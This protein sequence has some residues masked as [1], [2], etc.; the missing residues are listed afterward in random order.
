MRG[1]GRVFS[2]EPD[3]VLLDAYWLALQDWTLQDFEKAA[4]H[5]IGN[6]QFMPRPNDFNALRRA[7]EP[8]AGEAWG[9]ALKGCLQWRNPSNLP[10]GRIARAAAAVGGFRA[11][12]MA[13]EATALPHIERRFKEAY[14]ELSEVEEIR[15][16]L[17]GIAP[18]LDDNRGHG[19]LHI[20]AVAIEDDSV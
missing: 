19:F 12:A 13:D 2:S 10:T 16:A 17:P 15:G 14:D 9:K 3:A 5:L 6:S 11:I 8:T 20:T 4:G 1:M 7:A 18:R